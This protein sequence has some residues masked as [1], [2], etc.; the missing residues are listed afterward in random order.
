MF[1]TNLREF[2]RVRGEEP[3]RKIYIS[4]SNNIAVKGKQKWG[5]KREKWSLEVFG[6]D[7]EKNSMFL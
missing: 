3:E 4:P 6:Y 7:D 2:K 1:G 5:N